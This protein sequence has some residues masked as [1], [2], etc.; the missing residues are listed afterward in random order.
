MAELHAFFGAQY[1]GYFHD[2]ASDA[3]EFSYDPGYQ[4]TPISL[5]LPQEDRHASGAAS[6]FLDNLLPD[7]SEV[8]IRWARERDLAST[9]SMDLLAAYGEDVAGALTLTP[10]S[11]LPQ[12][13]PEPLIPATE[14]DIAGRIASLR[15]EE[16]AWIDQRHRPRMSLAGQQAKF[17][18]AQVGESW[19]WPTFERPSTHIFKPPSLAHAKI[20]MFESA[21]LDLARD[22]GISATRSGVQEFHGEKAFVVTRWDRSGDVRIHAED[23]CQALGEPGNR[24]YAI[25]APRVVRLLSQYGQQE[26]FVEQFVFNACLGNADAHA[27]NYSVILSGQNVRL[28][29]LYD[30][31]PTMFWEGYDQNLAMRVGTATQA[32]GLTTKNW[33][34]FASEARLDA[35]MVLEIADR[36]GRGVAERLEQT[37]RDAGA[38][39]RQLRALEKRAK[40]LEST[41][42]R[43]A[44]A[45]VPVS[46]PQSQ[47]AGLASGVAPSLGLLSGTRVTVPRPRRTQASGTCGATTSTGTSCMRR[48]RCPYHG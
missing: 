35:D 36:I 6:A 30:S 47:A 8:R 7:R 22:L 37:F 33:T 4:G 2:Q 15:R 11:S 5:S 25:N 3:V 23:L 38:S 13:E 18:L 43:R 28:A 34:K 14:D 1:V 24:K 12:R 16:T 9:S 48:G 46:S 10:D 42:P 31:I 27:K 44:P 17:S 45:A 41:L 21:S 26:R 32:S 39:D 29:P 19:V 40:A 20:D